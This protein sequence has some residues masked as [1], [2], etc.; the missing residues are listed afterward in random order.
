MYFLQKDIAVNGQGF[1][2]KEIKWNKVE[3]E[4]KTFQMETEYFLFISGI[5]NV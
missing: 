3:I 1:M 2:K 5:N 4:R